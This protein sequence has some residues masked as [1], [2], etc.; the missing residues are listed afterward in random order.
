MDTNSYQNLAM[1]HR[2]SVEDGTKV[3]Q[4]QKDL[5]SGE[6]D[7]SR[8]KRF[9]LAH[10]IN[11]ERGEI[12]FAR[13][14]V[15][16]EGATEHVLLPFLAKKL[17]VFDPEVSIV[18]TGSKYNLSLYMQL[19]GAFGLDHLVIHDE[20]PVDEGLTGDK[21]TS[22]RRTFALNSEIS[23]LSQDTGSSVE[24]VVPDFE[25]CAGISVRAGNSKGKPLAALDHFEE[26]SAED[27][28]DRI[29]EIV[30]ATYS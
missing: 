18:D 27:I 16:V 13:K 15:F 7:A 22:A 8:K 21:L 12:F 9:N 26:M 20:D 6:D 24:M 25:G 3:C 4:C 5:F 29:R 14:A 1:I 19:A 10:W 30:R 2:Y 17:G 11:P 23:T 28:P